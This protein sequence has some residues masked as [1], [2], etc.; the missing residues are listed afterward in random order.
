MDV[1]H[2]GVKGKEENLTLRALPL[3]GGAHLHP[4][5]DA[6]FTRVGPP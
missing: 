3:N 4:S 1:R 2:S 5:D 6:L